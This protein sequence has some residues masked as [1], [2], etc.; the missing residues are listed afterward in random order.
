MGCV[1]AVALNAVGV[2]FD[3]RSTEA[4]LA[5]T[6]AIRATI[7]QWPVY[8]TWTLFSRELPWRLRLSWVAILTLLNMLAFPAFLYAKYKHKTRSWLQA[9]VT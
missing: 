6:I 2:P 1:V 9:D 3:L 8:M 7:L 4:Q 5:G